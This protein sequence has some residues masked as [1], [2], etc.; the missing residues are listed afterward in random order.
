M[1]WLYDEAE[2]RGHDSHAMAHTIGATTSY[3][4]SLR[5]G[6]KR[7]E[8]I[9]QRTVE[10]MAAYLGVPPV[11]V[12]IVGGVLPASDFV[13]ADQSEEAVLLR[14]I[15]RIE[16]DPVVRPLLRTSLSTLPTD[17]QRVVA[18]LYAETSGQDVFAH[19]RIPDIVQHLQRASAIHEA[20]LREAARQETKH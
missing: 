12:K 10:Q 8:C 1:T 15:Q 13:C 3:L 16:R 7:T 11:V 9:G 17:A 5:N 19:C 6:H 18:A 20:S 14:T 4:N 2:I